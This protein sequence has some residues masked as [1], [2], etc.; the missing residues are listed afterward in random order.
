MSNGGL[1]RNNWLSIEI[2]SS[3]RKK[4][5]DAGTIIKQ[6]LSNINISFDNMTYDNIHMTAIF[7]GENLHKLNS[8]KPDIIQKLQII[9][10]NELMILEFK[11][12]NFQLFPPNKI[13]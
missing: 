7:L 9:F 6:M 5:H 12:I 1:S 11:F 10:L 4:L 3:I 2:D 8:H 13:H